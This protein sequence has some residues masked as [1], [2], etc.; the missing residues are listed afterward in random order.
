MYNINGFNISY[1]TENN[2]KVFI[3]DSYKVEDSYNNDGSV[4]VIGDSNI[5]GNNNNS[6]SGLSNNSNQSNNLSP[7]NSNS[8]YEI[9]NTL[10]ISKNK[11]FIMG[12]EN[13]NVLMLQYLLNKTSDYQEAYSGVFDEHTLD[14]LKKFQKRNNLKNVGVMTSETCTALQAATE[15]LDIDV[16]VVCHAKFGIQGA[17]TFRTQLQV[18]DLEDD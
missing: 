3:E 15:A 17:P 12:S 13:L 6:N 11:D 1:G 10:V 9:S 5:N 7:S 8:N 2:D 14:S 18:D 4:F 16:Q